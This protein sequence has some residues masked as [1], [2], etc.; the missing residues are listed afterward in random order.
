METRGDLR[1]SARISRVCGGNPSL[2]ALVERLIEV[3]RCG[4]PL[5]LCNDRHE[6]AHTRRRYP[7]QPLLE[8]V[9][10]RYGAIVLLG[11]CQLD[12][13]SQRPIL[14]GELAANFCGHLIER[15][16]M[17]RNLG[18]AALTA[19]AAAALEHDR[20]GQSLEQ[21]RILWRDEPNPYTVEA[22]WALSAFVA[23][24][25]RFDT[26][27]DAEAV[28]NRLEGAFSVNAG[29][30]PHCVEPSRMPWYRSHVACF[31]DQVYP[32]QAMSRLHHAFGNTGSL[33][34]A[35]RCAEQI[36]RAQGAGG[37][38]WW[39]YDT[40][41]GAV[42]EGYPVYSV[43]QDSMA[44]MAL[45]DLFEAGGTDHS[46]SIRS[47]LRW[48]VMRPEIDRSLIEDELGLIWRK[49]A[50]REPRKLI[51]AVRTVLSRIHPSLR[52]VWLDALFPPTAVDHESRP[53]HL[54]WIL[55]SWLGQL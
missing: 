55:H 12:F 30:F 45:M 17:S 24:G 21:L 42:I 27:L 51:R 19:W 13:D 22:S 6:F 28:L 33:E 39:H 25:S 35:D 26:R 1:V 14:G 49:V 43:H 53:Y 20:L 4:L 48:M 11:V 15:L 38:W 46:E 16:R 34:I 29:L 32:I 7:N 47:G 5:M 2:S 52:A 18:D 31:A 41:T 9:S 10:S 3:A 8:G 37:Q 54:G 36:C 23:A 40:R 50:R 44:P